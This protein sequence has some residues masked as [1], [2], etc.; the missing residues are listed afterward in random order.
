MDSTIL[1]YNYSGITPES[2]LGIKRLW[3]RLEKLD[4][5]NTDKWKL[6]QEFQTKKDIVKNKL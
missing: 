5:P 2:T 1:T 3:E 4:L 6:S